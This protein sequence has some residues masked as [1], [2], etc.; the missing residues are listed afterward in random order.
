M[1]LSDF[2]RKTRGHEDLC[3]HFPLLGTLSNA[4]TKVPEV[5]VTTDDRNKLAIG[6]LLT[7]VYRRPSS[8]E[9]S[10]CGTASSD[11]RI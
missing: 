1:R 6:H 5:I 9:T 4:E 7:V 2:E 11:G 10:E 3:R 8:C